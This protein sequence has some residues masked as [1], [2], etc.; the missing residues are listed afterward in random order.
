MNHD[1]V[2]HGM[3]KQCDQKSGLKKKDMFRAVVS[4]L[5]HFMRHLYLVKIASLPRLD[6]IQHSSISHHFLVLVRARMRIATYYARR[7]V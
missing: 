7:C 6:S 3:W 1:G 5:K 4:A 2:V